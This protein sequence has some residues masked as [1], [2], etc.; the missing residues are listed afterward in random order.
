MSVPPYVLTRKSMRNLRLRVDAADGTLHVSAPHRVPREQ[1]DEFVVSKERWI[2]KR[3]ALLA[4]VPPPL[5][6]G[7]QADELEPILRRELDWLIPY[8]CDRMGAPIPTVH[9]K[10]MRS[11]WGSCSQRTRRISINLELALRDFDLLEYVVVHEIAHLFEANHGPGFYLIMDVHLPDWKQ[12]RR[13]LSR[14]SGPDEVPL[15]DVDS[16]TTVIP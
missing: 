15:S 2:D 13:R 9:I 3:R 12:R 14:P 8:W 6:R 16:G 10:I 11:R 7:T 5:T 1:I 4:T